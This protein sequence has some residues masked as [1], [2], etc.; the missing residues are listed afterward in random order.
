M[1]RWISVE[2][3]STDPRTHLKSH[4][5]HTHRYNHRLK[6]RRRVMP[7]TLWSQTEAKVQ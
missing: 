5:E 2:D 7:R 3:L 6:E 4:Q 1:E